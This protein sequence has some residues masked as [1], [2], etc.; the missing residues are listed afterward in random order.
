[1]Q[2][3]DKMEKILMSKLVVR[4]FATGRQKANYLLAYQL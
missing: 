2:S 3:V 4:K 1:M